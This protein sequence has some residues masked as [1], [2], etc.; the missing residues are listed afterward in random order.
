MVLIVFRVVYCNDF[1][2]NNK[3]ELLKLSFCIIVTSWLSW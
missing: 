1:H 3:S 2:A